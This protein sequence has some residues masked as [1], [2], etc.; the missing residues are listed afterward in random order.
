[1]YCLWP[2]NK[3]TS[4]MVGETSPRPEELKFQRSRI[5]TL[6]INFSTLKA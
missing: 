3:A 5:T 1:V 6:L 4:E 2:W